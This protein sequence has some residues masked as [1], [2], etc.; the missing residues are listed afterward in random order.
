MRR[1]PPLLFLPK[2]EKLMIVIVDES[3]LLE[4]AAIHSISWQDSHHSFCSPDFIALHTPEHQ[5]EYLRE[6]MNAG[7]RVYMLVKDRP[8]GVVSVTGSLIEDLYILPEMQNKGYGTELLQFA[9]RQCPGVPTL[10][11]L[12]NNANAARLYRRLGFKETGK[13]NAITDRLDEIEFSLEREEGK[14]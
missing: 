3:N 9:V 10:W 8:V 12:E 2:R 6:K 13:V 5:R 1:K 11:I 7:S 4:A 14:P